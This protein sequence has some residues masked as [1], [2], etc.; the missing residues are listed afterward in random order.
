MQM[1]MR[2]MGAG[3][4]RPLPQPMLP[5]TLTFSTPNVSGTKRSKPWRSGGPLQ[6]SKCG[7]QPEQL[8]CSIK[9]IMHGAACCRRGSEP[10]CAAQQA[11]PGAAASAPSTPALAAA[12]LSRGMPVLASQLCEGSCSIVG[13]AGAAAVAAAAPAPREPASL[14]PD[15]NATGCWEICQDGGTDPCAAAGASP[16]LSFVLDSCGTVSAGGTNSVPPAAAAAAAGAAG[17]AGAAHGWVAGEDDDEGGGGP[18]GNSVVACSTSSAGAPPPDGSHTTCTAKPC[19]CN[20]LLK[21]PRDL[22]STHGPSHLPGTT[23]RSAAPNTGS[24]VRT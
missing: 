22:H 24:R 19:G 7:V 16:S 4:R 11:A 1:P 10:A 21:A 3:A 23:L 12:S 14:L 9:L 5:S 17:A 13:G 2:A 18:G 8:V 6:P 15:P 20:L